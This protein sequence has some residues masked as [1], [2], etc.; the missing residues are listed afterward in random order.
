[1]SSHSSLT[2]ANQ[3]P[4]G[5]SSDNWNIDWHAVIDDLGGDEALLKELIEVYLAT[6]PATLDEAR[7]ALVHGDFTT[8]ARAAHKLK[9]TVGNFG[10]GP[11]W[12]ASRTLEDS[13]RGGN[14]AESQAA[15]AT[16]EREFARLEEHLKSWSR[17]ASV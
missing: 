10:L 8:V 13:A 12:T 5:V 7:A 17:I 16:A 15:F 3:P 11:A 14:I 9:G 4:E 1:M 6:S 2:S